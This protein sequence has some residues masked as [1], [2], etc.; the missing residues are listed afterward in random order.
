M[1]HKDNSVL[2]TRPKDNT[3]SKYDV[4]ELHRFRDYLLKH[5][6]TQD[7]PM[8]DDGKIKQGLDKKGG[9]MTLAPNKPVMISKKLICATP[10]DFF[11]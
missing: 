5:I 4:E 7:S 8:K 6:F 1:K 9:N 3:R 2:D 10:G 11:N